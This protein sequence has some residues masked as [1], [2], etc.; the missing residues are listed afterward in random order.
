LVET[1]RRFF[2]DYLPFPRCPHRLGVPCKRLGPFLAI[3]VTQ[4]MT[5][6]SFFFSATFCSFLPF[7]LKLISPS[8]PF[9]YGPL[10]SLFLLPSV[11][12]PYRS[13]VPLTNYKNSFI[14]VPPTCPY[15]NSGADS[16]FGKN[17]CCPS[18]SGFGLSVIAYLYFFSRF[19][20]MTSLFSQLYHLPSP[21]WSTF[22]TP[23][24]FPLQREPLSF[25]TFYQLVFEPF[26]KLWASISR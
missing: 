17:F 25:S 22:P 6:V 14:S 23:P 11:F 24:S 12:S 8:P 21:P 18:S 13:T 10:L 5:S 20:P 4:K 2:L 7:Y 26:T 16:S 9:P 1:V 19:Q 15:Y 3:L